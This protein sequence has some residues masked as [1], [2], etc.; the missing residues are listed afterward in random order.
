MTDK[1]KL[2]DHES[3]VRSL[4]ASSNGDEYTAFRTL[5]EAKADPDGIVVFEGDYGGQIYAVAHAHYVCCTEAQL[6][7]L[8]SEL[9]AMAWRDPGG[10]SVYYESLPVGAGVAGG[11]GGG[12]VVPEV[13]VHER[14]RN[15]ETAIRSVLQG[16]R[17]S[18]NQ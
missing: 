7:Q 15:Y 2:P 4:I 11:M 5:A 6:E 14:L 10:R 13:W 18:I 3:G 9:D 1:P 16:E 12:A 17:T 8:L